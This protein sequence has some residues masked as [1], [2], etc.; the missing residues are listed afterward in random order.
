[1]FRYKASLNGIEYIDREESYTSQTC[2][3]C[4]TIDKTNRIYRGLYVCKHYKDPKAINADVIGAINIIEKIEP[5]AFDNI[6]RNQL[7]L[8]PITISMP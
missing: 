5:Q 6:S 3:F 4:G 2:P 8:A 1:M 7:L